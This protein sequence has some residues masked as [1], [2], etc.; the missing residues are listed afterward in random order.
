MTVITIAVA[1]ATDTCDTLFAGNPDAVA[2]LGTAQWITVMVPGT[3]D[4]GYY[5][6]IRD[7]G[8]PGRYAIRMH[9]GGLLGEIESGTG[10][11]GEITDILTDGI[12][13]RRGA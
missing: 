4:P 7:T 6:I 12:P 13:L 3:G 1:S 11:P 2:T 8:R 5:T 10:P 9:P